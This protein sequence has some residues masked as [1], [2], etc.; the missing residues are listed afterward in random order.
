MKL[1]IG[2]I[3][4][5]IFFCIIVF[6]RACPGKKTDMVPK[7][8]YEAMVQAN[9]DTVHYFNQ[10][11]KADSAAIDL[12]TSHSV[13][14]N[15]IVEHSKIELDKTKAKVLLLTKQI[16]QA[17]QEQPNDAWIPVSPH[18]IDAC[19]SL[20]LKTIGLTGLV[21]QYEDDNAKMMELMSYEVATR[22]TAIEHRDAFNGAL[23]R[24]LEDCHAKIKT[25]SDE[26]KTGLWGGIGLLGNKTTPIGGGEGGL[27]L[28]TKKDKIYEAK[29]I[30][31]NKDWWVGVKTYFKIF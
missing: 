1:S 19:D 16:E 23:Q 18:Y 27:L 12:A 20:R 2:W 5:S 25:A 13:Q 6:M 26:R 24:Q 31:T 11:L 28:K 10:I 30:I 3:F 22:D 9:K 17:K 21:T 15:A 4:A 29:Y 7:S 14:Q 8:E